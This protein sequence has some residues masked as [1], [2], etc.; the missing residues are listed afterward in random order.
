MDYIGELRLIKITGTTV[1][2]FVGGSIGPSTAQ[3]TY[4]NMGEASSSTTVVVSNNDWVNES[5]G[6]RIITRSGDSISGGVSNRWGG[7]GFTGS[8]GIGA[9]YFTSASN[10]IVLFRK[11]MFPFTISGTETTVSPGNGYQTLNTPNATA[12]GGLSKLANGN[13]VGIVNSYNPNA[14]ATYA[15]VVT[16]SGTTIT[17]HTGTTFSNT[18]SSS[19]FAPSFAPFN[20]ST[21]ALGTGTTGADYAGYNISGTTVSSVRTAGGSSRNYLITMAGV[22]ERQ[23]IGTTTSNLQ[24]ITLS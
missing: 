3:S 15:Y 7:V 21:A 5:V 17:R 12:Y 11:E 10:G 22:N 24:L 18:S 16:Q 2:G 13:Y 19:Q 9:A 1:N 6:A 4:G 8:P 23:W 14:N 20:S